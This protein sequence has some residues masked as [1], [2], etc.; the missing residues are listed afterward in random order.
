MA[1]LDELKRKYDLVDNEVYPKLRAEYLDFV[2]KQSSSNI[3]PEILRGMLLL[4]NESDK[5]E[6]NFKIERRKLDKKVEE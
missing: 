5:W 6:T 4:I 3:N 1:D 2:V